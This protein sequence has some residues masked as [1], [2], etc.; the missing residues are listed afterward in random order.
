MKTVLF[1]CCILLIYLQSTAQL[2]V[3]AGNDIIVCADIDEEYK[4]GGCP[5]AS[6]G[7]EPYTYTWSGKRK[8]L[9]NSNYWI[10]ASDI[11]DDTTKSNPSFRWNRVPD[12]WFTF[13]LKVED[14]ENNV[15]YDSVKVRR[16]Y[17]HI[18]LVG[19][20]HVTINRGDSVFLH[21]NWYFDSNF[22]PLNFYITPSYGLSDSTDIRGWAKPDTSMLYFMYVVNP[23]GCVSRK[24]PYLRVD[25]IDTTIVSYKPVNKQEIKCFFEQGSLVVKLPDENNSLYRLTVHNLIGQI[26]H[27]GQYNE[28]YLR[29]TGL[30]LKSNQS[31]IISIACNDK[32]YVYKLLHN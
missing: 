4:I 6:G 11:L 5:V 20:L 26:I 25:V 1:T 32:K 27:S 8:R 13:Y 23:V 18:N 31:Y 21:G 19:P 14:A 29:L 9:P 22:W 3:D 10:L 17:F 7:I 24:V 15:G 30:G 2:K 12:D 28:P 16:A